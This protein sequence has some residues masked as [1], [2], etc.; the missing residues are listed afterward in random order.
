MTVMD[1][2]TK[3]ADGPLEVV[4]GVFLVLSGISQDI[5]LISTPPR[6][7]YPIYPV[8]CTYEVP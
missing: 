5:F 4:E 8:Y 1:G 2:Y 6:Y 3:R 7:L